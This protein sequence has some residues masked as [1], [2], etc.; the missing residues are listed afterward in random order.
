M[1]PKGHYVYKRAGT[2]SLFH[3]ERERLAQRQQH[4]RELHRQRAE[5]AATTAIPYPTLKRQRWTLTQQ[6]A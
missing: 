1:P 6:Q 3:K 2:T 4:L 5:Q